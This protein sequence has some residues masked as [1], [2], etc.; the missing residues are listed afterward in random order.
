MFFPC[1]EPYRKSARKL[2][3]VLRRKEEQEVIARTMAN[4][5]EGE[6]AQIQ[7]H[8]CKKA[9]RIGKDHGFTGDGSLPDAQK[10]RSSIE[11]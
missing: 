5:V 8:V 2:N 9:E 10:A 7:A 4:L 1:D 11:C 3:R 6:G